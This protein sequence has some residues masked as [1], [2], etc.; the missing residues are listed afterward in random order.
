MPKSSPTFSVQNLDFI[1]SFW[2]RKVKV[3]IPND[4]LLLIQPYC[5]LTKIKFVEHNKTYLEITTQSNTI[6]FFGSKSSTF[7]EN[8][9]QDGQYIQIQFIWN[10]FVDTQFEIGFVSNQT[11][12]FDDEIEATMNGKC[13]IIT[14]YPITFVK[15]EYDFNFDNNTY[16]VSKLPRLK[17]YD[18]IHLGR[19]GCNYEW[20]INNIK[21]CQIHSLFELYV[22]ISAKTYCFQVTPT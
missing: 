11:P 15:K 13:Q 6:Q 4:L 18:K 20:W 10:V 3:L 14:I 19:Q 7:S 2:L 5:Q 9:I 1:T 22:K 17:R 8:K 21:I 16:T 12:S